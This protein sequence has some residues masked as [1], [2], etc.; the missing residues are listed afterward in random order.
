MRGPAAGL[1]LLLLDARGSDGDVL[2]YSPTQFY[3]KSEVDHA[4]QEIAVKTLFENIV[5]MKEG[6]LALSSVAVLD[7]EGM[8][9]RNVDLRATRNG[10]R[11]FTDYYPELFKK[12]FVINFPRWLHK[13]KFLRSSLGRTA[14]NFAQTCGVVRGK[15]IDG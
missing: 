14:R 3:I 12:I 9:V 15:V 6:P 8:S 7:F 11:I 13:S 10:I 5:Y 4:S 2:L 1:P